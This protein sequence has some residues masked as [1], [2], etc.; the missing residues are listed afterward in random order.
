MTIPT[1]H[2]AQC[3]ALT[4][5]LL[6]EEMRASSAPEIVRLAY[7][8]DQIRDD[9]NILHVELR[10]VPMGVSPLVAHQ[11]GNVVRLRPRGRP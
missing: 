2:R 7:L 5:D 4:A 6:A 11:S 8:V 1:D 10:P 9:A 3:I